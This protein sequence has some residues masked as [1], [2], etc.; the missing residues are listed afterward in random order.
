MA[1]A[2]V[3]KSSM[4][5]RFTDEDF[6]KECETTVGVEFVSKTVELEGLPIKLQIW[7][8]VTVG[9]SRPDR[10]LSSRSLDRTIAAPSAALWSTT[11]P[12]VLPSRTSRSG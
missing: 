5:M 8:T 10:R 11:C 7:D 2:G 1:D 12:T 9:L 6:S 3:G 4:L